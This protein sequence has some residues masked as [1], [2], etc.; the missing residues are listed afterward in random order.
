MSRDKFTKQLY[1]RWHH[2]MER[3]Y[4]KYRKDYK[5]YGAKGISVDAE[6][7]WFGSFYQWFVEILNF[8]TMAG[9]KFEDLVVD[10]IDP[11]KNYGPGNCRLITVRENAKLSIK[12]R[13][14]RGRFAKEV[15]HVS[16]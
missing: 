2:I 5:Y 16:A 8:K 13:D 14:S 1:N 7:H 4:C 6:W 9:F 12:R 11:T 3:C 10:R 15:V